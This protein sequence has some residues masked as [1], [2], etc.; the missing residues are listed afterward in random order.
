MS[1]SRTATG[2][3]DGA[4]IGFLP[5]RDGNGNNEIYVMN[6]D[7]TGQTR[8]TNNAG[9]DQCPAWSQR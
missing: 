3:P 7:G 1:C 9:S 5:T 8:L 2:S 6:A 4:K